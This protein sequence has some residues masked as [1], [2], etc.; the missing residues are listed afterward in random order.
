MI[1]RTF[2]FFPLILTALRMVVAP[3][4]LAPL[5]VYYYPTNDW[6]LGIALAAVCGLSALTDYWDG[7]LARRYNAV[8]LLG[9][10]LDPCADKIF[11]TTCLMALCAVGRISLVTALLF[12]IRELLI[13]TVREVGAPYGIRVPVS[14]FAK[15][16][17]ALIMCYIAVCLLPLTEIT[18]LISNILAVGAI[19]CSVGSAA[20]YAYRTQH[21]LGKRIYDVIS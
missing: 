17:T 9:A 20:H 21:S 13:A 18:E 14:F 16:K 19:V 11:T 4:L 3:F 6:Q 10:V 1:R 2:Y 12:T 15:V 8:T 5:I 7:W